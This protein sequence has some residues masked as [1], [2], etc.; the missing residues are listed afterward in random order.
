[1]DKKELRATGRNA[2]PVDLE[3]E[4][5]KRKK[6]SPA[7]AAAYD[8]AVTER[9]IARQ[10][11]EL[12]QAAGVSQVEMAKRLK[13]SQAAISRMERVDYRGHTVRMLVKY[14]EALGAKLEVRLHAG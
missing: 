4:I 14:A 8:A 3:K 7:F 13:T 9:D 12:R 5:E 10:L 2:R 6:A 11:A 1:M